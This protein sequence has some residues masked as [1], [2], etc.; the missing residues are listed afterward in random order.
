[1]DWEYVEE[2]AWPSDKR[3]REERLLKLA[4]REELQALLSGSIMSRLPL[5]A[6]RTP[7]HICDE[8]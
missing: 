7:S 5:T 3:Q 2:F 6:I 1:M 8:S 4:K